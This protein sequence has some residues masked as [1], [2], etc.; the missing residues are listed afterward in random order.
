MPT[1]LSLAE[2][3]LLAELSS[4]SLDAMFDDQF[5]ENGSFIT[6]SVKNREGVVRDYFYYQGYVPGPGTDGPKRYSKYVGPA[7]DADLQARVKRFREIKAARQDRQRIVK[8]LAGA[9]L[10]T[11]PV[12]MGRI[13]EALAKA[14]VFRLR[15]V[16][17]GT[18]A[19]QTYP[20]LTGMRMSQA[21]ATTG[22]VDIAQYRSISMS[23][24]D[25]TP[26]LLDVLKSVDGSFRAVP[27]QNDP[28]RSV[29]FVNARGFRLDVLT[30]HRGGDEQMGKPMS[31]DA[32]TGAAA[33]P[34]RF[35]DYLLRDPVR[36]VLL[37][38]PGVSINVPAPERFAVHKMIISGRRA[39][40]VAGL[41]KR[42]KDLVQA[43]EVVLSLEATGRGEVLT[44]ALMEAW[45]RGPAWR[46]GVSDAV[47]ALPEQ[48]RRVLTNLA[49]DEISRSGLRPPPEPDGSKRSRGGIAE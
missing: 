35:L 41:A 16:L 42:R 48:T 30:A 31:M 25:A 9:G 17:V 5:P 45:R 14:G 2:H 29:A 38:G 32:L 22:D 49:G 44:A 10:P 24:D 20:A 40:D 21:A 28:I 23:V 34:L 4:L 36:S 8:A 11:P 13:I 1:P 33:E 6:R 15:A 37:Y 46:K 7:D 47:N 39:A 3:T 12:E 19:Y 18:G 43:N 26:P 27:H